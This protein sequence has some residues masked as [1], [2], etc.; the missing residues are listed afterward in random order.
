MLRRSLAFVV[1]TLA[2][3]TS[4]RATA[5]SFGGWTY[6]AP[7]GYTGEQLDDHVEWTRV[8]NDS[9]CSIS[10][11]ELRPVR[12]SVAVE[13]AYEWHNVVMPTFTAKVVRRTKLETTGGAAVGVTTAALTTGDG[14]R[15]AGIHYSVMPPGMIGSVLLTSSS[16]AALRGC[17]R[18]ATAVV[19]SL[20]VDW[21]SPRFTDPEARVE[22][23]QGRWAIAGP[24][25]RE[26]TF[27]ADGT[28]RFHSETSTKDRDR[29]IDESGTYAV[30]GNQLVLTPR[31]ATR[32]TLKAGIAK[33]T[34]LPLEKATYTWS[35][36]YVPETNEWRLVMVPRKP[37]VRD[38]HV[39]AG[40]SSYSDRDEPRWRVGPAG[41][42]I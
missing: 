20:D 13:A 14:T 12:S 1:W 5:D 15:Y 25:S 41:P 39:P 19:R 17:E 33:Q 27:A 10:I 6:S 7:P 24:T 31:S 40:G 11:F 8:G 22:T 9:F 36:L 4:S 23:P 28:Y 35:K 3:T 34:A 42:A 30:R 26:Y 29:T 32:T 38:G 2:A 16:H 21:S 18:V 37:T